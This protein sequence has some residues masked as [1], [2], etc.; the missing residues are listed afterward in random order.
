VTKLVRWIVGND[1]ALLAVESPEFQDLI[2]Y[3]SMSGGKA[4]LPGADTIKNRLM[5][6][7]LDTKHII[8]SQ[9]QDAPGR[10]SLTLDAWS[11]VDIRPFISITA[12]WVSSDWTLCSNLLDFKYLASPHTGE[13]I[14]E[15]VVES[16]MEMGVFTRVRSLNYCHVLISPA[17][18]ALLNFD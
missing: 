17:G 5:K 9:L 3:V 18:E 2:T 6:Q 12:H 7:Y 14:C 16:I 11:S 15:S 4:T 8:K 13:N 10:I 1:I